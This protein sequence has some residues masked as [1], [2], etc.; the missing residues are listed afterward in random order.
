MDMCERVC[1]C[2]C[3]VGMRKSH[4]WP[5]IPKVQWPER[6]GCPPST[7][8]G[9]VVDGCTV[10][11]RAAGCWASGAEITEA[12]D[13][14]VWLLTPGSQREGGPVQGR[15]LAVTLASAT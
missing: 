4:H 7:P 12:G 14:N 15:Q 1:L 9:G 5:D 10:T 3:V 2:T 8:T 11:S 6:S 13:R